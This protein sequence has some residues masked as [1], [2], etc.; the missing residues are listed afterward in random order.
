MSPKLPLTL[1]V[2]AACPLC[3]R[4]I[5]WLRRHATQEC[6]QLVDISTPGFVS[7]DRSLDQLRSKLHAR[8]ADGH[9]LTGLDA[10]YWSWRAAGLG[11]WAAP[12][13]WRPLRPLLLLAYWLFSLARP[14]LGWLPHPDGSSRCTDR[15]GPR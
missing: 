15:C 8:S 6:L 4:E 7:E 1:Y 13:G 9:W 3:A 12:L 2:D 14:H 10:T 5:I 11:K